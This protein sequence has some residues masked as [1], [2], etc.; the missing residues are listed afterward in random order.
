M[1]FSDL[2]FKMLF[3]NSYEELVIERVNA[4][5]KAWGEGLDAELDRLDKEINDD[6]RSK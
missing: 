3:A 1:K 2:Q 5:F 4:K 6:E